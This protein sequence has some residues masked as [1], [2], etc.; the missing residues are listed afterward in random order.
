MKVY[1]HDLAAGEGLSSTEVMLC[2]YGMYLANGGRSE[3]FHDLTVSDIQI[4]VS[5]A[6]GLEDFKLARL[7]RR[8]GAME[9]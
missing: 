4:M 9:G 8:I 1:E 2:A 5:T 6:I 3:D 7:M